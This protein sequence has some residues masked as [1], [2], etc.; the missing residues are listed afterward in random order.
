MPPLDPCPSIREAPL[1][2]LHVTPSFYPAIVYGGPS[3]SVYELC[4]SIGRCDVDVRVLTTNANGPTTVLS[5]ATDRVIEVSAR[6]GVEYCKRIANVAI[7][8]QLLRALVDRVR[9]ADVVHLTAVYSFPT[10]PTLLACKVLGKPIVWSPRG[11]LQR[12]SGSRRPGLK[13]I[14][15]H[16]CWW[17]APAQSV[18]HA[19]SEAEKSESVRRLPGLRAI[20]IPNGVELPKVRSR[21]VSEDGIRFLYLGRIDPKR[22]SR[23]SF[24]PLEFCGR[25]YVRKCHWQ[26]QVEGRL[27]M[28]KVCRERLA[29]VG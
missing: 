7:S 4:K 11:M 27:A 5:V 22:A 29:F 15:E 16:L 25:R 26:S 23:T 10:L 3:Y 2:V 18:L 28:S 19:T 1:R 6:V 24:V 9:W 13:R 21:E 17:L 14:W 20:V 12:W 8:P